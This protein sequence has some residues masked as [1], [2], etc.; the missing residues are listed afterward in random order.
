MINA[1][2]TG[3]VFELVHTGEDRRFTVLQEEDDQ[4]CQ[5]VVVEQGARTTGITY[6]LRCKYNCVVNSCQEETEITKVLYKYM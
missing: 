3:H 4:Q 2:L 1:A 5:S 6:M